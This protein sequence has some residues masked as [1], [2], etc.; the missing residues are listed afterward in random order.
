[1]GASPTLVETVVVLAGAD[2]GAVPDSPD[3][4]CVSAR[5]SS[6]WSMCESRLFCRIFR[7]S[8]CVSGDRSSV[9][10][11]LRPTMSIIEASRAP[12]TPFK[13][14]HT[15][16]N[17]HVL[18]S[19]A[20]QRATQERGRVY[21]QTEVLFN[22]LIH[23]ILYGNTWLRWNDFRDLKAVRRTHLDASLAEHQTSRWIGVV[24]GLQ[25]A[26]RPGQMKVALHF[27]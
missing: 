15:H 4:T 11:C 10:P 3:T 8:G 20:V 24:L 21:E 9:F 27:L 6:S 2:A 17:T 18:P 23:T 25:P 16:S 5:G 1:M 22:T 12:W 26:I 19:A 14:S 13:G 7:L